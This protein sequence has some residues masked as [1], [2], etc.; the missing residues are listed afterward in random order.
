MT[1]TNPKTEELNNAQTMENLPTQE[2]KNLDTQPLSYADTLRETMQ[3]EFPLLCEVAQGVLEDPL[4]LMNAHADEDGVVVPCA[5]PDAMMKHLPQM[6][7][8]PLSLYEDAD[9]RTML[10]MAM[11]PPT[12]SPQVLTPVRMPM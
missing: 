6:M 3:E 4:V 7:S 11:I 9:V 2:L 12:P 10:L 1:S 5:L 8:E